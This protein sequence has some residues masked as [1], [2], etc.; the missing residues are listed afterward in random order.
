MSE[1]I[2]DLNK[3]IADI[4]NDLAEL[5]DGNFMIDVDNDYKGDFAQI[6][7]SFRGIDPE[8]DTGCGGR[9]QTGKFYRGVAAACR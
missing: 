1:T 2:A 6:S 5:A 3:V 8:C 4:S 9:Y 7:E